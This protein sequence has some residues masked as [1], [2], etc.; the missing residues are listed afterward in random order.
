MNT[1][2]IKATDKL[3]VVYGR[4]LFAYSADDYRFLFREELMDSV[5]DYA[6]NLKKTSVLLL[7]NNGRLLEYDFVNNELYIAGDLYLFHP[8][9]HIPSYSIRFDPRSGFLVSSPFDGKEAVF[10]YDSALKHYTYKDTRVKSD[11]ASQGVLDRSDLM[12]FSPDGRVVDKLNRRALSAIHLP[13]KEYGEPIITDYDPDQLTGG[14]L[15]PFIRFA[16]SALDDENILLTML[17]GIALVHR[18]PNSPEIVK[19]VRYNNPLYAMWSEYSKDYF[20]VKSIRGELSLFENFEE[21]MIKTDVQAYC[22]LD[23][24]TFGYLD[25][26]GIHIMDLKSEQELYLLPLN[27]T[28]CSFGWRSYDSWETKRY[29]YNWEKNRFFS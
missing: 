1:F 5:L 21:I 11:Y 15:Y 28:E 2:L 7:L 14:D 16:C 9:M 10:C 12:V 25:E 24:K 18:A 8:Q 6:V 17:D 19:S 23:E 26:K 3:L 13:E 27:K 20:I 22:F 4:T 29:Y